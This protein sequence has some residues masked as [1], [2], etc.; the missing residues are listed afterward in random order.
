MKPHLKTLFTVLALALNVLFLD[1]SQAVV[2]P[3]LTK[4]NIEIDDPH[5]SENLLRTR[6]LRAVKVNARSR[7]NKPMR[8]LILTV[9]IYKVG[10]IRDYQVAKEEISLMGNIYSNRVVKNQ[11]TYAKCEDRRESKY[12]GVAY[13]SA[14]IDGKPRKTLKVLSEK[15][16]LLKCGS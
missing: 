9:E 15:T 14:I 7:C 6:N 16:K 12:Y 3:P 1:S 5:I 11:K 4:C 8:D 2:T 10:L 13:A